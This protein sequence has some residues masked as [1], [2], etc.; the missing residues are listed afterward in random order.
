MP[1]RTLI[2]GDVHGCA[3]TLHRLLF[4]VVRL[5]RNDRVYFLGDLIDRGP[6]SKEVLDTIMRLQS[7][8][9][10]ISSVRGNHEEMLLNACRDR[11]DFRLW[12]INGGKTTLES[13]R[14][15]DACEIPLTYHQFL[16]NLPLYVMLENFVLVHAGINCSVANPLADRDAMLWS[17]GMEV[18]PERLGNRK[19]ICAHTPHTFDDIMATLST[20]CI[21]LDGGCVY[22]GQPS[23]G[24]LVALELES[25]T[26]Y[27]AD[28]CDFPT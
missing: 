23:F 7:A 26:L 19:V 24:K 20:D 13:F 18:D 14:A 1:L 6:R 21:V 28:N 16:A 9:Y 17:R 22:I 4:D 8:G 11:D 12:M 3:L 27:H 25:M 15:D 2:I 5:R 10:S